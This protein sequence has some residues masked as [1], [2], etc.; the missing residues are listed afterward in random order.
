MDKK[1]LLV[2]SLLVCSQGLFAEQSQ[3]I[4]TQV[5]LEL[6]FEEKKEPTFEEK[7]KILFEEKLHGDAQAIAQT[8]LASPEQAHSSCAS[9]FS[10]IDPAFSGR[11]TDMYE[12]VHALLNEELEQCKELGTV[13]EALELSKTISKLEE[14][15]STI[16]ERSSLGKAWDYTLAVVENHPSKVVGTLGVL[17]FYQLG[18]YSVASQSI[19]KDELAQTVK[20]SLTE[21][22]SSMQSEIKKSVVDA[23]RGV[24]LDEETRDKLISAF[25]NLLEETGKLKQEIEIG[26]DT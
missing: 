14:D 22:D 9:F 4:P 15:K 26:L 8:I 16:L 3:Q 6:T 2:I 21:G 10:D 17:L 1:N 7:Q 11:K 25:E 12:A 5:E 20:K 23:S 19:D 24:K 18:R 13:E